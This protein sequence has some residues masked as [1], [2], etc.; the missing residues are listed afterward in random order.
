MEHYY[1][2]AAAHMLVSFPVADAVVGVVVTL[3]IVLEPG[4]LER[5]GTVVMWV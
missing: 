1:S 5:M 2:I 3:V 4:P